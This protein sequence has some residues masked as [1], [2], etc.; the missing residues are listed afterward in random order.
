MERDSFHVN[1]TYMFSC[2]YCMCTSMGNESLI[3]NLFV[4]G[5]AVYA[6]FKVNQYLSVVVVLLLIL[7]LDF[8]FL[9]FY[10]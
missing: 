5:M 6:V 4:L 9:A 8:F 1:C 3:L 2:I 7:T 10:H